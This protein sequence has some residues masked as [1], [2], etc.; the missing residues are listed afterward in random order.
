MVVPH[1]TK[2]YH[3]FIIRV[4]IMLMEVSQKKAVLQNAHQDEKKLEKKR[5]R[6]L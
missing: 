2:A 1:L 6:S 3:G 5:R 4:K